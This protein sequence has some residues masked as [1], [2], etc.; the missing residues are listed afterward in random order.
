MFKNRYYKV[1]KAWKDYIEARR[2]SDNDEDFAPDP[3]KALRYYNRM[4]NKTYTTN[5]SR[6]NIENILKKEYG[7]PFSNFFS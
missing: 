1:K 4:L 3:N 2:A 7:D 5:S 6:R